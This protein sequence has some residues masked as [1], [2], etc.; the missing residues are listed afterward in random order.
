MCFPIH[1]ENITGG[2]QGNRSRYSNPK[3][4]ELCDEAAR[5]TDWERRVQL[6]EELQK[7]VADDA[8]IIGAYEQ[9]L[10]NTYDVT[11]TNMRYDAVAR[12]Y[13]Y[14]I[15]TVPE[16]M[17]PF[18]R[19]WCWPMRGELDL[20][21]L[22]AGAQIFLG[23]HS[24]VAFAKSGQPER[25]EMCTVAKSQWSRWSCGV[26]FD[27]TANRFLHH[28]VRYM[29][30]T[31]VDVALERRPVADIYRLLHDRGDLDTSPPAPAE[32]LFLSHVE[33]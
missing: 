23:E 12:S 18:H 2:T 13:F 26:Q 30:G 17:S 5:E 25:G 21:R 32:G 31:M 3:V 33:Y 24:F 8:F 19:R 27:V 1:S 29:V 16:A 22:N 11:V 10:I 14:R 6:Y 20:A 7:I 15:G 28:M 9:V 4:D